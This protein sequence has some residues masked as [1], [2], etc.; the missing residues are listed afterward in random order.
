MNFESFGYFANGVE[1][2]VTFASFDFTHI[3]S[4]NVNIR[5]EIFLRKDLR[6]AKFSPEYELRNLSPN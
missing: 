3:G 4:V 6:K 5:G 2:G 1:W